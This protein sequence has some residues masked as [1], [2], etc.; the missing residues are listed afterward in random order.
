VKIFIFTSVH[1]WD[2][3]RIFYKQA[4]SLAKKFDVE[5][6][7]PAEFQYKEIDNIK[8][9]G[10][11]EWRKVGDRR[12][13]RKEIWSRI[14]IS[15][16][17]VYHFHD[18]ELIWIGLKTKILLKK[19][20]V[21]DV[22]EHYPR[23]ILDKVWIP[24]YL[25]LITSIIFDIY[26]RFATR[27][28]DGV[29]YT[30]RLM[31]PRFSPKNRICI[32]NYP[33]L[34]ETRLKP[35]E[36]KKQIIYVGGITRIRGFIELIEALGLIDKRQLIDFNLVV[37]GK[38]FDPDFN[39]EINNLISRLNLI[40]K[41]KFLGVLNHSDVMSLIMESQIGVV[42]YLPF[43]NNVVCMPNKLF[44]YMLCGTAVIASDF[45]LYKEVVLNSNCGLVVDPSRPEKIADALIKLLSDSQT[46]RM[47]GL[48]GQKAIFKF[49]NW[50]TEENKLFEFYNR[51]LEYKINYTKR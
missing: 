30:T 1:H 37:A 35:A 3:I 41:V 50:K 9:F 36:K 51:F 20:V 16:A 25:R 47:M 33:L 31:Q 8:I 6:H 34:P 11:P 5:L 44:E 48:N 29:V 40:N 28:F 7:A 14:K 23:A 38:Y 45:E 18:P 19:K 21:Y 32:N 46:T 26:E 43:S 22:H 24:K 10:L 39:K 49:Y 17:E 2:D 27:Y 42:T 13:I 12:K 4:R 15:K